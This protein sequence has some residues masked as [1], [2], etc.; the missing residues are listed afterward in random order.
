MDVVYKQGQ[1]I[2]DFFEENR[3]VFEE[4]LLQE[5]VTVRERIKEIHRIGNINLISNAHTLVS[6]IINQQEEELITFSEQEGE[7]WAKYSLTLTLKLEWVQAIRRTLWRFMERYEEV[8]TETR[9][10]ADFFALEKQIN[11]C[12]DKFLNSFFLRYSSYKD[13]LLESQQQLVENLSVPFIPVSDSMFVLPLIG[14]LDLDRMN[15]IEEKVLMQISD[16][17][18]KTLIV[19]L[20]GIADMEADVAQRLLRLIDGIHIM[21]SRPV[22]TG[23]RP[24]AARK[25]VEMGI[26]L[27]SKVETKGD[28]QQALAPYFAAASFEE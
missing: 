11:D 9:E 3:D 8:S 14:T 13:E 17:A 21:G 25:M 2:K 15:V 7:A 27:E 4:Q 24:E 16:Q 10:A 23:V 18:I 28:L 20:S 26:D 19:D 5:A 12:V 1:T 6:Y 22:I